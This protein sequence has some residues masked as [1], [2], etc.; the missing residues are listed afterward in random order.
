LKEIS[1]LLV[2]SGTQGFIQKTMH[3]KLRWRASNTGE[4]YFEVFGCQKN[5]WANKGKVFIKCS[6]HLMGGG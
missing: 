6:L 5:Y 3:G 4:L 1:R 2:E